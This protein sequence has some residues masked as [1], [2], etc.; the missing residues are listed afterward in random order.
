M[1]NVSEETRQILK[2]T[3]HYFWDQQVEITRR[4]YETLFERYPKTKALF[5]DFKAH[6]PNMFAG[7]LMA[8][9]LSLDDPET[10]FSFRVTIARKHVQAGV[11]EEHYPM[12]VDALTSAMQELLAYRMDETTMDAWKNWFDFLSDLLIERER[13]GQ[14]LS[15][16]NM[17]LL[18]IGIDGFNFCIY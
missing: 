5:K 7:A 9:M 13:G 10:L 14:D 12:L 4:M 11:K 2:D 15:Y 17:F 16:R 18:Y 8:H 3:G 1:E 6:Q